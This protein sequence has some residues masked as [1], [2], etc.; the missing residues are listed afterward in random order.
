M[1]CRN[2]PVFFTF[3]SVGNLKPFLKPFFKPFFQPKFLLHD[4][5]PGL[6]DHEAFMQDVRTEGVEE[7]KKYAKIADNRLG[8]RGSK[9][10]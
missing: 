5:A 7:V 4:R 6:M 1:T 2:Y 9:H 8:R 10:V 3:P